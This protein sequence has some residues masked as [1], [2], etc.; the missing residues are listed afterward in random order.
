MRVNNTISLLENNS[1]KSKT[2]TLFVSHIFFSYKKI[3]SIEFI[4]FY[5]YDRIFLWS[6]PIMVD[7][8][9][10][11]HRVL[12][13]QVSS[14]KYTGDDENICPRMCGYLWNARLKVRVSLFAIINQASWKT[15]FL[16]E[17]AACGARVV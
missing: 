4:K 17:N 13:M 3:N 5:F 7:F 14:R 9:T 8:A 11:A 6:N 10:F 16:H 15:R 2:F 1:I 12:D